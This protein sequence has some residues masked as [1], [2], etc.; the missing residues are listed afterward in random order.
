MTS[1]NRV[2]TRYAC[3][4]YPLVT[5]VLRGE[6]GFR[7]SVITDYVGGMT[8]AVADQTLAAGGDLIMTSAWNAQLGIVS[9]FD[10]DWVRVCL[11][12]AAH[13]TLF[14][15]ANSLAMNGLVHGAV[16]DPGFPVY[17]IILIAAW[18][19]VAAGILIGGFFVYRTVTWTEER[20]EQRRRISK[21]GWI[22]IGCVV[23]AALIA[24]LAA[25]FVFI[26]PELSKAL[27]M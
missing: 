16:Y 7:G 3:A 17:K 20:W 11:R 5:A 8:A 9:D 25:F 12:N 4:S 27:V 2:G 15:Q 10:A 21:R 19:V 24:I 18:V 1:M 13:N 22:I 23:A 6:W 26:W 14:M